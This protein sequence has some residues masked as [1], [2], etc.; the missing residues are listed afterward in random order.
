MSLFSLLAEVLFVGHSLVGPDLPR[1]VEA[2]LA[3][4]EAPAPVGAQV[5][6]GASLAWNWDHS[7]EA[8]VDGRAALASGKV[9]ALV[10][11]DAAGVA[12]LTARR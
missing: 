5:I 3:A 11:T 1:M 2:G 10:L 6:D 4:M 9:G 7:S 12:V 8:A